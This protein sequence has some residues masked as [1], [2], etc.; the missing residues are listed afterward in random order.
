MLKIK[1]KR[2][3][4][5]YDY[6]ERQNAIAGFIDRHKREGFKKIGLDEIV[7]F[8]DN[9][10]MLKNNSGKSDRNSIIRT[11]DLL[12]PRLNSD[13]V[14]ILKSKARGRGNK[15]EYII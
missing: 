1:P 8:I 4:R 3:G 2:H 12:I 5:I 6:T 13:N 11:M 15:T 14:F 9:M 10:Q 7:E